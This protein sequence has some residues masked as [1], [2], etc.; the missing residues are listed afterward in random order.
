MYAF[1]RILWEGE[2]RVAQIAE[3]NDRGGNEECWRLSGATSWNG[4]EEASVGALTGMLRIGTHGWREI[5]W[6]GG[7]AY[8]GQRA[9][10]GSI[11]EDRPNVA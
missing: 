1:P 10:S 4:C 6:A 7:V 11:V 3:R 2:F 8:H 5:P 9:V